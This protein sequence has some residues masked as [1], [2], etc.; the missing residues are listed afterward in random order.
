MQ[1]IAVVRSVADICDAAVI[2]V[3]DNYGV[4]AEIGAPDLRDS[5]VN[6]HHTVGITCVG[7]GLNCFRFPSAAWRS[8]LH[9]L[10]GQK[11]PSLGFGKMS[12]PLF[13]DEEP[14]AVNVVLLLHES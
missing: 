1:H 11:F 2:H 13:V 7:S 14:S 3:G 10:L 8:S 5:A 12:A 4:C 9:C 6:V